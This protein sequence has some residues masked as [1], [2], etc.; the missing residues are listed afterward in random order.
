MNST[1][2]TKPVV[3]LRMTDQGSKVRGATNNARSP[4]ELERVRR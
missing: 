3:G 2:L 1:K 4:V